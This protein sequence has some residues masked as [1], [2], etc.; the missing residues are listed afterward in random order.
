MIGEK[1]FWLVYINVYMNDPKYSL[2]SCGDFVKNKPHVFRFWFGF[3]FSG[4]E[5]RII[6]SSITLFNMLVLYKK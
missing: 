2:V 3:F 4:Q 1:L 5:H 6:I